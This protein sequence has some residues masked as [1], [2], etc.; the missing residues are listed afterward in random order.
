MNVRR[1]AGDGV[2]LGAIALARQKSLHKPVAQNALR[3]LGTAST[4][5]ARGDILRVHK[6]AIGLRTQLSLNS[7]GVDKWAR[8]TDPLVFCLDLFEGSVEIGQSRKLL[9][10]ML[11]DK[12]LDQ[13]LFP[14][15]DINHAVE[16][17]V[18]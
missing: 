2:P 4:V 1:S 15:V 3:G 12:N 17:L 13:F 11:Y 5:R 9:A 18:D 6:S 8:I 7:V 10:A 14:F 16:S